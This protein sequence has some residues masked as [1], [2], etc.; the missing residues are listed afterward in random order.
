MSTDTQD[1]DTTA[2]DEPQKMKLD[3]KVN[4]ISSCER[5]IE[6]SIPQE[7][8]QRYFDMAFGEMLPRAVVPGFRHGKAPRKLVEARFRKEV[9]DQVKG[10][11]LMDSIAQATDSE[12]LAAISEPSFDVESI[13][14][15][16]SGPMKFE[17]NLEVRPEF[18]MPEW[19]GLDI[20]RPIRDFNA[21]DIDQQ[22][23]QILRRHG[24]LIPL[25]GAAGM[26][27][28]IT[29]TIA[30]KDGDN[31]ISTVG[32]QQLCIRP[33]LSFRDGKV[34]AFDKAIIGAK[35]GDTR[36]AKAK[37]SADAP[38]ESLRGKEIT[39]EFS[40]LDVKKLEMPELNAQFLKDIGDF[41]NEGELRDFVMDELKRQLSYHQRQRARQQI[42]AALTKGAN[43]EL[44]PDLLRRQS[45]REL[46]RKVLELKRSGF[47]DEV[48]RM[49]QNDLHHNVM[50][51]TALSLKEHFILE[52]LAEQE[53]VSDEPKDYDD[54]IELIARQTGESPRRVRAQ[55]EKR[56]QMDILR[57]QIIE[58]KTIDV[59]LE[60]AKFKD[61]PFVSE[62]FETEA[63]DEAA[64]GEPAVGEEIPDAKP[65]AEAGGPAPGMTTVA[66]TKTEE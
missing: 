7:D 65:A 21:Q 42:T 60:K 4:T 3:V 41:E 12:K 53:N 43:W 6:I 2:T 25:E 62:R 8:V 64:S 46:Q 15:P 47:P 54:E 28:Y 61:I 24:R 36:T 10:Q 5:K 30:F 31:V 52:R 34:E 49:H 44:P 38:N 22:L 50:A 9:A 13:T 19:K 66:P 51:N 48:I 59:V 17:F 63:I 37:I 32:E 58:R 56:D 23:K 27:D 20:E 1:N 18:D 55:L 14:V 45:V 26:G 11:L 35:A 16:D 29:A 40:I 33:V 39:A 57:N